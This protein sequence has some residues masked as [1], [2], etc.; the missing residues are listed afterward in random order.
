MIGREMQIVV[1]KLQSAKLTAI[2]KVQSCVM[3]EVHDY[4]HEKGL[5]QL[6]P[7]II[8]PITDPLN[9]SVLEGEI[10]YYDEKLQL[11]KS[12]ILHK[13]LSLLG[14]R[15][16]IYIISPNV[17]LEPKERGATG[18][19][20][21]EFTQVDFE[22]K[23]KKAGD[24]MVF[25]EEL[26]GRIFAKVRKECS[27]EL[28]LLGRSL[29]TPNFPLKKFDSAELKRT[30]GSDWEKVVSKTAVDPIWVTN[31]EREFYDKEDPQRPFTYLNYD[32]V[33]P[34]GFGEGLSGAER[35]NEYAQIL[36]RM[37]RNKM[38][39]GPYSAYLEV[40]RAGLLQPSAGAGFG[41]ERL[42]R[43]LCG[44]SRIEEVAP[45]AKVPGGKFIF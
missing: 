28:E 18:R 12:M 24:V 43:Y 42:V 15:E 35:E 8:S 3:Q 32:I 5:L 23:G 13:Q 31:H 27:A 33:Y 4:M 9:H 30:L 37:Q 2:L 7:V 45:F 16:G 25:M 34:E 22:L 10:C 44:T 1:E 20:L 36:S 11:T 39:L 17:R 40:A 38:D 26:Y 14:D 21:L 6:M 41:V 29:K 19:H